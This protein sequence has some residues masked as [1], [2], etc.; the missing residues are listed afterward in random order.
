MYWA[1]GR[2]RIACS[3]AQSVMSRLCSAIQIEQRCMTEFLLEKYP[4][5]SRI[6]TLKGEN[7]GMNYRRRRLV[8]W[9]L[10]VYLKA[11]AAADPSSF[12]MKQVK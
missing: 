6:L 10:K 11:D 5:G 12:L 8:V 4:G 2:E 9:F 3:N 7:T 1:Q